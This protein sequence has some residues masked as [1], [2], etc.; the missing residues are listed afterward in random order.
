LLQFRRNTK[1]T[2]ERWW[3]LDV[4]Q[5]MHGRNSLFTYDSGT[6]TWSEQ[7]TGKIRASVGLS[8]SPAGLLLNRICKP[9]DQPVEISDRFSAS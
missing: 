5:L 7:Q 4:V 2:V 9:N 8:V 3:T 6:I 1:L